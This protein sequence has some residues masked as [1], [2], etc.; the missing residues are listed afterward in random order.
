MKSTY[1]FRKQW[2]SIANELGMIDKAYHV[3]TTDSITKRDH[4][5]LVNNHR[6]FVRGM[7]ELPLAEQ[8]AKLVVFAEKMAEL[9]EAQAATK[10]DVEAD[11]QGLVTKPEEAK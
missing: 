6:R 9:K 10:K 2:I 11:M 1:K 4:M 7:C 8:Q 3:A 5:I